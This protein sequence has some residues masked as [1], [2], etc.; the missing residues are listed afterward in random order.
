MSRKIGL[1]LYTVR[2]ALKQDFKGVVEKV[3]KIGYTGV[4]LAGDMGGM[5]PKELRKFLD[6]LGLSVI[7][8]HVGFDIVTSPDKWVAALE[9]YQTL[10]AK[11]LGLGGVAN[12]L[13]SA[14]G[15]KTLCAG[16]N[17]AAAV[18]QPYGIAFTYH[19]HDFEFET[20]VG[21]GTMYDALIAGTDAKTVKFEVDAY[22]VQ[23]A[24]QDPAKLID[25]LKGRAALIHVKDM[26]NDSLRYFE[27][28]GDGIM[29]FD[30]LFAACER[31]HAV[32]YIVEQDRCPKGEI[33][34]ITRSYQYMAKKK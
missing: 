7:G 2:D 29:D 28:V 15:V 12:D 24:R 31:N 27:I 30:G 20:P 1:Q 10:G 18:A 3:A 16:I 32:W 8:G 22:W 9:A 13:R 11:H 6:G 4:E 33:E 17:A 25:R 34:S 14:E 23:F 26:T 5:Q 19:N 21:D